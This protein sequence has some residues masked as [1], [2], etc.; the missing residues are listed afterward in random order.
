MS[1]ALRFVAGNRAARSTGLCLIAYGISVSATLPYQSLYAVKELGMSGPAF[2]LLMSAVSVASVA[3]A[4]GLGAVSDTLRDRRPLVRAL[5]L[6]GAL[7][8]GAIWLGQSAA[9]YVAAMLA[10]VPLSRAVTPL[11]FSGL[12]RELSEL[13][14]GQIIAVNSLLRTLL[15]GAWVVTPAFAAWWV[16]GSKSLAAVFLIAAAASFAVFLAYLTMPAPH[17]NAEPAAR[18]P[19]SG[20]MRLIGS[21]PV[22]LRVLAISLGSGAHALHG[23]LH[24][25]IMT[26]PAHGSLQ[27]V[28]LFA[29]MLAGLE[30]PFMLAWAEV[31]RHRSVGFA[32]TASL[33]IYCVYAVLLSGASAPWHLYALGILNSCGAAAILSL[34][35]SY[36]QDLFE[37]R[38]GLGS[39]LVPVVSFFGGL[40]SA[41]GFALGT[42]LGGYLQ[43]AL[44]VSALCAA[45]ALLIARA[46]RLQRPG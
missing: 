40:I 44:I 12:R 26:G 13:R 7:G 5:A 37:D 19:F 18:L 41:A 4:V 30:I 35:M 23:L 46:D 8:Y 1:G 17:A 2:A 38:P 29:G 21:P 42:M 20:L 10:L 9:I 45:G 36:F 15:A 11:L 31:A 24:P 16:S 6:V 3:A 43:S 39:S 25:L 32:L 34:P 22:L 33:C 28:G 14:S 27:D